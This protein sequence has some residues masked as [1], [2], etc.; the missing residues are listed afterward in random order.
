MCVAE[1]V[2]CVDSRKLEAHA[3]LHLELQ[4]SPTADGQSDAARLDVQWL[5]PTL[6][7]PLTGAGGTALLQVD[8]PPED[9]QQQ[10]AQQQGTVVAGRAAA[11]KE[12]RMRFGRC[13]I[14]HEQWRT[15]TL[16]NRGK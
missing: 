11:A 7:L 8:V 14:Y 2:W 1:P 3:E 9:Q 15:I 13:L 12:L 4:Y 5:G 10:Q 6:Q 16:R